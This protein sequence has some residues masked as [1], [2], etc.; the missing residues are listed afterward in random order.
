MEGEEIDDTLTECTYSSEKNEKNNKFIG[1]NTFSFKRKSNQYGLHDVNGGQLGYATATNQADNKKMTFFAKSVEEKITHPAEIAIYSAFLS[2]MVR[3]PAALAVKKI[4]GK[5]FLFYQNA[6]LPKQC[7]SPKWDTINMLHE[8][9][10]GAADRSNNTTITKKNN[11]ISFDIDNYADRHS[12]EKIFF[13]F[14][15]EYILTDTSR[16]CD[17]IKDEDKYQEII[18]EQLKK[19][20]NFDY[21]EFL[22]RLQK[23][24]ERLNVDKKT[25]RK[26][27]KAFMKRAKAYKKNLLPF[28][29]DKPI[30]RYK[31]YKLPKELYAAAEKDLEKFNSFMKN[32]NNFESIEDLQS[33][34]TADKIG[35]ENTSQSK[36]HNIQPEN[37]VATQPEPQQTNECCI[38]RFFKSLWKKLKGFFLSTKFAN[39][40]KA[41]KNLNTGNCCECKI[42]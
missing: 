11:F 36:Q 21:E 26:Y 27:L 3:T 15:S 23:G 5:N 37:D 31:N 2:M 40:N 33:A 32:H 9:L 19:F 22:R 1:K 28:L 14:G 8:I 24:F 25:G 35:K 12:N 30:Q 17:L 34:A 18:K 6:N 38:K 4:E 20:E 42:R 29:Q 13:L 16:Y 7:Y 39:N 10:F 41:Q